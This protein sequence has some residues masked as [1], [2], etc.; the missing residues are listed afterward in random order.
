MHLS[1]IIILSI[2]EG[3]T[4]FLPISSTAHLIITAHFLGLTQSNFMQFFEI[5]IQIGAIFSVFT[6][7]FKELLTNK[8]LW[9]LLTMSFIPTAILGLI[10]TKLLR[11]LVFGNLFVISMSLI[12]VGILFIIIENAINKKHIKLNKTI[13]KMSTSHAL[14]I[15]TLQ[16]LAIIPGVSRSGAVILT[17]L[18][19]RYKRKDAVKYSFLL[20]LPTISAAAL[21]D[22]VK[23]KIWTLPYN[24]LTPT[25]LGTLL[26]FVFAYIAVKWLINYIKTHDLKIFGWYR[27]LVGLLIIFT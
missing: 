9:I 15:G 12:I 4:E 16:A 26:S 20:G 19:L 13:Y 22:A 24:L 11:P 14:I 23:I 27:I 2:V 3:I 5:F 17:M 6:I 18:L 1:Y 8:K 7:Y 25:I 10:G 21:H